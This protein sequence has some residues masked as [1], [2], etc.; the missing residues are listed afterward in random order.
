MHTLHCNHQWYVV[1]FYKHPAAQKEYVRPVIQS[2]PLS[3]LD[4]EVLG[5]NT[6]CRMPVQALRQPNFRGILETTSTLLDAVHVTS[7]T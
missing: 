6:H 1:A 2:H 7:C 4:H 5:R 3:D